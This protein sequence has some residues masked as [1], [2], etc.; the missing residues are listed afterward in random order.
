[1]A[2]TRPKAARD[3]SGQSLPANGAPAAVPGSIQVEAYDQDDEQAGSF[4]PDDGN[5]PAGDMD[6]NY[7]QVLSMPGNESNDYVPVIGGQWLNYTVDIASSG[8]YTI[9]ANVASASAGSTFHVEIDGA[10]KTGPISIPNTGSDSTF[11]PVSIDNI[12]LDAG[13]HMMTL[14]ID[15]Y[16][17]PAGNFDYLS[18]SPYYQQTCN[19][20]QNL[21][22]ACIRHGGDWDY[23]LCYCV[24]Y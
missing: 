3:G 4:L 20:P 10:D 21:V 15:G 23:D 16:L 14:V 12:S 24:Y 11:Q 7:P 13:Q 18:I 17:Q 19:P 9:T 6:Y 5:G 1:M 8:T 2:V 22:N